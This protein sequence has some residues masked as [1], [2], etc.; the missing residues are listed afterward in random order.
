MRTLYRP[1]A[2][3]LLKAGQKHYERIPNGN[4]NT[5][6]TLKE[7]FEINFI[8]LITTPHKNLSLDKR[9][10]F[11]ASTYFYKEKK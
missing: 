5:R 2:P 10:I 3:A 4:D 8:R 6:V 9:K 7:V 1:Y 11:K